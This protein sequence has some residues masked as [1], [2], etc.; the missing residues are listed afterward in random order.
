MLKDL[1]NL[2][3]KGMSEPLHFFPESSFEY[4]RKLLLKNQT[5][6]SALN[7]AKNKWTGNDFAR[8]ESQDPYFERASA[9][10]IPLMMNLKKFQSRSLHRCWII[11]GKSYY[12]PPRRVTSLTIGFRPA[13]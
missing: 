11:V 1:L 13:K 8:G 3:W 10:P 7:S 9:E 12:K 2:F 4:A 5:L 6:S